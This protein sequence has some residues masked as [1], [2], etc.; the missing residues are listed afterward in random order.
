MQKLFKINFNYDN[1]NNLKIQTITFKNNQ[2]VA[3]QL[4]LWIINKFSP[5]IISIFKTNSCNKFQTILEFYK[6]P[7]FPRI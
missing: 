5:K 2:I 7:L 4:N 6:I 3:K 1:P